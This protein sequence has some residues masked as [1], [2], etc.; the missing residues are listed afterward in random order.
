MD[1]RPK[2]DVEHAR[3]IYSNWNFLID[4]DD[5][6]YTGHFK[7]YT[8]RGYCDNDSYNNWHSQLYM[9]RHYSNPYQ[10][11]FILCKWYFYQLYSLKMAAGNWQPKY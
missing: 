9:N 11:A 3:D 5:R 10:F 1:Q 7:Q 6:N 2:A 8:P 4:Y